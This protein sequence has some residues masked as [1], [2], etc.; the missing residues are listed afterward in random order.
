MDAEADPEHRFV[1]TLADL[2]A[3][4]V[5][6]SARTPEPWDYTHL[7]L[8]AAVALNDEEVRTAVRTVYVENTR[9]YERAMSRALELI[10]R[11]L[12]EGIDLHTF[13]AMLVAGADGAAVR[14]RLDPDAD[15]ELVRLMYL[16]TV[17]SMTRRIDE[18]DDLFASRVIASH[19]PRPPTVH[20]D[21]VRDAVRT[22]ERHEGWAA[23]TVTRIVT[24]TGIAEAAF[25][26]MYPTRHHLATFVW[27]EV[28]GT[29]ERRVR[30]RHSL[31][32]TVQVVELVADLAEA[33][34]A[35]RS[36]VAS[37]LTARLHAAATS[38]GEVL[39]PS[40]E[41]LAA[42]LAELLEGDVEIRHVAARTAVDALLMGAAASES[43]PDELSRVLIAGL[44]SISRTADDRVDRET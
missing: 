42:L 17:A 25:V 29:L 8:A 44:A 5:V 43:G 34:C 9:S 14:L 6:R 31:D 32:T 16:S 10:G 21:D 33:A 15:P 23:V 19:R 28:L 41:R 39:D 2:A 11:T 4:P 22:V 1:E 27:D 40:S 18:S 12:V 26:A 35:R 38:E 7:W 20:L 37:L 13:A 24:L 30:A 36:L 3:E